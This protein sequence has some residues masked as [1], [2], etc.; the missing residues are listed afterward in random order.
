M[1]LGYAN[2]DLLASPKPC[3]ESWKPRFSMNGEEVEVIVEPSEYSTLLMPRQVTSG[4]G[5]EVWTPLHLLGESCSVQSEP[6]R[7]HLGNCETSI[8]HVLTPLV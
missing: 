4:R 8:N 5:Q 1:T 6:D 2:T 7:S 3:E